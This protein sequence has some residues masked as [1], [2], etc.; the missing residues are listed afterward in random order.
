MK[1]FAFL[2]LLLAFASCSLTP[3]P[4][5][6]DG[7]SP[8]SNDP[9]KQEKICFIGDGGNGSSEQDYVAKALEKEA[10]TRI[11][12]VGDIVYE[13]GITSEDD[14]NFFKKFYN[15]YKNL[16]EK[17][18]PFYM[19]MGNHD[20]YLLSSGKHWIKISEKYKN[21]YYPNYHYA[22]KFGDVCMV[23]FEVYKDKLWKDAK[24]W[25]E[26]FKSSS[27][28]D[29]CKLNIGFSHYPYYSKSGKHGSAN[30]E[31]KKY[32]ESMGVGSRF[33]VYVAGHDHH[34]S[35]EGKVGKTRLLIS[36]SAGK[37]RELNDHPEYWGA[38]KNGYAVVTYSKNK[39]DY[40]FMTV[41]KDVV[42]KEHQGKLF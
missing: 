37:L 4:K 3:T 5:P 14:K 2:I 28:W 40:Y 33:H 22:V 9:E 26:T 10:C 23:Q 16:I 1:F 18:I 38:S 29:D 7:T 6:I 31:Q 11:V 41:E 24:E 19:S 39:A 30:K 17:G 8:I 35:D 27:W 13:Y 34:L 15:P 12:Y 32:M 21:I 36:G 25:M 42:K 20:W